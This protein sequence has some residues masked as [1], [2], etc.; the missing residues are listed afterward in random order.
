MRIFHIAETIKGGVGTVMDSLIANQQ[1]NSLIEKVI[2][3]VP[4]QHADNLCKVHSE[5]IFTFERNKRGIISLLLFVLKFLQMMGKEKFDVIHLHS[6]FAGILCRVL[7]I[8]SR[9]HRRIKIIYSPHAFSFLMD[10]GRIK[11]RL[12]ANIEVFLSKMCDKI[13]CVSNNEYY[14]ALDVGIPQ[15]KLVVVHNGVDIKKDVVFKKI[16]NEEPDFK[17]LFVGRFDYQKG[18]DVLLDSISL[19]SKESN[20]I[21]ELVGDFVN[22]Q[23]DMQSL[24]DKCQD[25]NIKLCGWLT[26]DNLSEKYMKAD[27][28]VIPSRWEGFAMVPLEAMSYGVPIVASD[29][30][31]FREIIEDNVTGVLFK[32]GDCNSL[33]SVL[34]NIRSLDLA[35]M[36]NKAYE[37]FIKDYTSD[38][39][40][41]KTIAVYTS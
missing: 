39:M 32:N 16:N 12:Y 9:K 1:E 33:S 15:D 11:K 5:N 17:V 3:L 18:I 28:I 35:S 23:N 26:P 19:L 13:I 7:L 21:F 29:I 27:C 10:C 38:K 24:L 8:F 40:N 14:A 36:R 4:K 41:Q 37:L 30:D 6:S 34:L 31:A 22:N 20:I 25:N 2:C